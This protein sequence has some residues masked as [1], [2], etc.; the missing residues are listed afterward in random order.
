MEPKIYVH[1]LA[2]WATFYGVNVND[3]LEPFPEVTHVVSISDEEEYLDEMLCVS[4]A[5][6]TATAEALATELELELVK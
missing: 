1:S 5:E 2:A 3:I 4:E 6:A